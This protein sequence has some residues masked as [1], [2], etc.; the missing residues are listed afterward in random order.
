MVSEHQEKGDNLAENNKSHLPFSY[1]EIT[2]NSNR[3]LVASRKITT[4]KDLKRVLCKI[5]EN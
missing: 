2:T 3:V 5:S 4:N 1:S